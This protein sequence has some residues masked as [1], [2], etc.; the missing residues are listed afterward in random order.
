MINRVTIL[1]YNSFKIIYNR[2]IVMM[3]ILKIGHKTRNV[4]AQTI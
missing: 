1:S 3:M 2:P 4:E